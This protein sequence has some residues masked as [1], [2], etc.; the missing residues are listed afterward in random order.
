M[1]G[2]CLGSCPSTVFLHGGKS[3]RG[4]REPVDELVLAISLLADVERGVRGCHV[5]RRW[6]A[7]RSFCRYQNF[8]FVTALEDVGMRCTHRK[9]WRSGGSCLRQRDGCEMVFWMYSTAR[10]GRGLAKAFI[11]LQSAIIETGKMG[12]HTYSIRWGVL[13]E[14]PPHSLPSF[15]LAR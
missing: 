4:L 3:R 7:C 1:D 15:F 12:E 8:F 6:L 10:A 14:Q 5:E 13:K 9:R 2:V 11:P